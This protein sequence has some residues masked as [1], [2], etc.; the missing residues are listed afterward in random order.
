MSFGNTQHHASQANSHIY[1]SFP[2]FVKKKN[3]YL[4]LSIFT[5]RFKN[6]AIINRFLSLAITSCHLPYL[7]LPPIFPLYFQIPPNLLE[8]SFSCDPSQFSNFP[9]ISKFRNK[10]KEISYRLVYLPVTFKNLAQFRIF[11]SLA[12]I[13]CYLPYVAVPPIFHFCSLIS[14]VSLQ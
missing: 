13:S 8:Y 4:P 2:N 7:A 6:F 5:C 9:V 3:I 1:Q 10:R 14:P 12:I 11:M